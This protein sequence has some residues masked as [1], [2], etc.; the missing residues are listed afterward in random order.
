MQGAMTL[1][2]IASRLGGRVAGDPGIPIRQVASLQSAAPGEITF[3]SH[4]KYKAMLAATRAS[5]VIVAAESEGLTA[6]PRIVCD[7]PYLYF[8]RVSQLF[9]AQTR[10]APGVHPTA[11][12][13]PRAKIADGVSIGAGCVIGDDVTLGRDSCV[14]PRVVLYHGC[15]VG[16]RVI[17][18]S[19]VVIGADGFGIA[20]DENGAWVKIPQI[21]GVRIGNDVEIGANT[22]IDRGALDDTRIEDG[23]KLDN[24]IQIGHNCRIGAHTAMAGCVAVAGSADV[25]RYC[26]IGAAAVIL[27]HLKLADHVQISAGTVISR[28]I[29]RAG[30][31]TGMFPFDDNASWAKNAAQ[32]R[33]LAD[34]AE[35]VRRLEK[36]KKNG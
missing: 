16:E 1:G 34:L 20:Q 13:S 32:V 31:Y 2:E 19:G 6:L 30:K 9:N 36:E 24:Q 12:V 14:Y 18:H 3:L 33:H 4:P 23:V 35:R 8:A 26:T 28:S 27:G 15:S 5:A 7:A 25:G 10:Q 11:V 29:H 21:G 22:T 17:L